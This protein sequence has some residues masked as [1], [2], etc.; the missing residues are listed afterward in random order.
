MEAADEASPGCGLALGRELVPV[1]STSLLVAQVSPAAL[2]G[3]K[4]SIPTR[5][6]AC[7][8]W[9]RLPS[10]LLPSSGCFSSRLGFGAAH[11]RASGDL[12][13]LLR[14]NLAR[15]PRRSEP[16]CLQK[17]RLIH[18]HGGVCDRFMHFLRETEEGRE[19]RW[20]YLETFGNIAVAH[21]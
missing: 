6:T 16:P 8:G 11:S 5:T 2:A 19:L 3:C 18:N 1:L 9:P 21:V 17:Q 14:D 7:P 12:S 13:R 4:N 20:K 15:L 10:Q